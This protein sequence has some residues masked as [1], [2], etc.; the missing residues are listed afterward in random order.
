M[1]N[2]IS[3]DVENKRLPHITAYPKFHKIKLSE[4]F[5]IKLVIK[6]VVIKFVKVVLVV[7]VLL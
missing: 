7:F 2:N 3:L 6:F 5:V 4:R 1:E